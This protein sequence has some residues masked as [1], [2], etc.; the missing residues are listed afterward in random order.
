MRQLYPTEPQGN[1]ARHLNTLA[2][3]VTGIVLGKSCQLPK[4]QRK[5]RMRR[6]RRAAANASAAGCQNE[7]VTPEV[8]FL[9][10]IELL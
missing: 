1:V 2:G 4:W 5:R 6:W 10:F 9:P 7:T 8:Y 3:M